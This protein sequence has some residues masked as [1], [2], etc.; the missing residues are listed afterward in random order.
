MDAQSL[1]EVGWV[2]VF[3]NL[4]AIVAR[5]PNSET[6]K[7]TDKLVVLNVP[8]ASPRESPRDQTFFHLN[9]RECSVLACS[10]LSWKGR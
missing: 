1:G 3:G 5:N 10:L 6:K 7:G 2:S 8:W 9:K 4:Y